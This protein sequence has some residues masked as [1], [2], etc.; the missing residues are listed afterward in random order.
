LIF[1][2]VQSQNSVITGSQKNKQFDCF[3]DVAQSE[4]LIEDFE[5]TGTR[6]GELKCIHIQSQL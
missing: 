2:L 4:I 6:K 1:M 5:A 3:T